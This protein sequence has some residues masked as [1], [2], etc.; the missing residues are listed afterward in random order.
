MERH[1][2]HKTGSNGNKKKS[3]KEINRDYYPKNKNK[4]A[5]TKRIKNKSAAKKTKSRRTQQRKGI[6]SK[7]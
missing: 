7:L 5:D 4:N 2:T 3:R 6:I 1:C